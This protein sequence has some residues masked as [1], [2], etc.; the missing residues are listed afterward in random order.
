M[1]D[2]SHAL[3]MKFGLWVEPERADLATIGETGLDETWLATSEGQ[4]VSERT[5]Q[6]CLAGAAGRSVAVRPADHAHR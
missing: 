3:G 2:Y 5:G 6:I 1:T 4:P